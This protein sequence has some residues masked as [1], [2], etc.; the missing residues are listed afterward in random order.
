[1]ETAVQHQKNLQGSLPIGI[2]QSN[3]SI[4]SDEALDQFTFAHGVKDLKSAF[5]KLTP[6]WYDLLKKRVKEKGFTKKRFYDSVN[7]TIDNCIYPEPTIAQI[8]SFDVSVKAYSYYEILELN[9]KM[10]GIMSEYKALK[11]GRWV[12]KTDSE[13]FGLE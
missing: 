12:K 3:L 9:S 4:Y 8:L 1:M 5:P 13:K 2:N 10:P 7:H 11:N 6:G